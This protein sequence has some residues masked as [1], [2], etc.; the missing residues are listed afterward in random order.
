MQELHRIW[1]SRA[2]S[3]LSVIDLCWGLTAAKHPT[4][5]HPLPSSS[6]GSSAWLFPLPKFL[7]ITNLFSG[8]VVIYT[9]PVW[10]GNI[11]C[12]AMQIVSKR[13]NSINKEEN[14]LWIITQYFQLKC[15]LNHWLT[16][17]TIPKAE[18]PLILGKYSSATTKTWMLSALFE[19]EI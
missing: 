14:S 6:F 18:N 1:F 17:T 7:R 8:R 4:A 10:D 5:A 2:V 13:F 16:S 15:L 9:F 19:S 3:K 11:H 12:K